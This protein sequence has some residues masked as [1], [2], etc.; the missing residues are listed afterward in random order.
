MQDEQ[1]AEAQRL[2]ALAERVDCF[3][4]ADLT[5]LVGVEPGTPA[6]WRKRGIGPSYVRAGRRFFYPRTAVAEW[7]EGR[8]RERGTVKAKAVL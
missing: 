1:A 2:A 8:V 4:E 6:A 3:T 5:F 7:L